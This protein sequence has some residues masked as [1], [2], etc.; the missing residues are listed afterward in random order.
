MRLRQA[1]Q[2]DAA[3]LI[4]LFEALYSETKCMLMEPG[5]SVV[6]SEALAGR[7]EKGTRAQSE[8]WF[9]SEMDGSLNGF[10]Y[11]RRGVARRNRHSLYVVIGVRKAQWGLGIAG[12]LLVALE[13]WASSASIHR[14]ELTVLDSNKR[15]I[16][17]YAR[18]GFACEGIKRHSLSID[19]QY[20]DELYMAKLLSP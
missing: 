17:V 7:I 13:R 8:V 4:A 9:V 16:H 5:E 10:V 18:A 1:T 15:A 14:M 6:D 11:G 3:S 12:R 20:V 2:H 19:G